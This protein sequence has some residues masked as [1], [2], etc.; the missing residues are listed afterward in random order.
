[1]HTNHEFVLRENSFRIRVNSFIYMGTKQKILIITILFFSSYKVANAA[2]TIRPALNLGLVGYWSMDEGSGNVINDQSGNRNNSTVYS[3]TTPA[4]SWVDGKLGKALSFDG[5][6]DK[7]TITNDVNSYLNMTSG[8][9][10]L[11]YKSV[12]GA[13]AGDSLFDFNYNGDGLSIFFNTSHTLNFSHR[14][15]YGSWYSEYFEIP[16]ITTDT[17]WH[18]V[19]ATWNV[20]GG[21]ETMTFTLD[22]VRKANNNAIATPA[23]Y[24]GTAYLGNDGGLNYYAGTIDEVRIYNRALSAGEVTR[25]YNLT[26]PKI[27]SASDSGLVGYWSFDEGSGNKVGDMSGRGN[28]GIA[29][30]S[31]AW[32]NGRRGKALNFNGTN[33]YVGAGQNST[34]SNI[35]PLTA[36]AWI[37]PTDVS[38]TSR[39]IIAK[40]DVSNNGWKFGP[41]SS[42]VGQISLVV[43]YD[44]SGADKVSRVSAI[45][46]L[47][48]NTWQYA[49][50]TW[51]GGKNYTGMHI[52][53][54]GSEV[55]YNDASS[56][57]AIGNRVS[58]ATFDL[59]IGAN[60]NGL[61]RLFAGTIDEVRVYNRALSAGEV[62]NLYSSS[63]KIMKVNTSQNTKLTAGL[64]GMWSFN[65]PD[66]AGNIAFDRSGYGNNGTI[67]GASLDSGKVG[68]ALKF[69]GASPQSN[70]DAGDINAM[71]GLTSITVSAWL[72]M[73]SGSLT[74]EQHM[75]D[76][77]DCSGI[78][79]SSNFELF[80]GGV[81]GSHK[82]EFVIYKQGG[83]SNLYESGQSSTIVDDGNW[84][85]ILG[86]YDGS[87]VKIFVDG[88]EGNAFSVS[89]VTMPSTAQHFQIGGGCNSST[90]YYIAS[91]SIIDEVR[92]YNRALSAA[93]INRL[94][95]MGK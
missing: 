12:A 50:V 18:N 8:S 41:S 6:D 65:G 22:G 75:V 95:R 83:A 19:T 23:S 85:H 90:N 73:P 58:D 37:Y 30:G 92:V 88:Q 82:V 38:A 77:S 43:V 62:S 15:D 79:N 71:D 66:I 67:N 17:A 7:V 33:Q 1:M 36:S 44:N 54:N 47:T 70:V 87:K 84:H 45:N 26:K 11:W 86:L 63:K 16:D 28:D 25:L 32:I 13:A 93:E 72:K 3:S 40:T 91:G 29:S 34:L 59:T 76:K 64:V 51:D 53:I 56:Q 80:G 14:A 21:S 46:T 49:T 39:A 5:V 89:G 74:S 4:A 61:S 68:Q 2:I 48:I 60:Y 55:S 9:V 20:N 31:P 10:S 35:A 27:L 52:Y 24:G 81:A 78:T 57:N 94:Y 69:S 42:G